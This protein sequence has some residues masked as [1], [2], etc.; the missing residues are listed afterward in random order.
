MNVPELKKSYLD[1]AVP[2]LM[3]KLGY[4]NL[5]QVLLLTVVGRV[6]EALQQE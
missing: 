2:A 3:K 4:K 1:D 6:Y 5:H